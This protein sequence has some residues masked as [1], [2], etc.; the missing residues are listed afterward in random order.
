MVRDRRQVAKVVWGKL[1]QSSS[2]SPARVKAEGWGVL[3]QRGAKRLWKAPK[4]I[5]PHVFLAALLSIVGSIMLW[6]SFLSRF[7]LLKKFMVQID[8]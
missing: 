5:D 2:W 1:Q 3:V 7:Y 6:T 4:W 8:Y